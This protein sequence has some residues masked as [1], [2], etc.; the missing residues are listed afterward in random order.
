[1]PE[2]AQVETQ[3]VAGLVNPKSYT[4]LEEKIK[5]EEAELEALMKARTEEVEQ[6]A[7]KQ[8]QQEAKP[9]KAQEEA[10]VSGEERTYKKRYSDLRT[11][12]NKQAEEL[13]QMKAQ[14]EQ[15]QKEGKVRAPTSDES[16]D[17]W[18]KKYP[19]IA[20]IVE[21]IAEK[22]AQEKF[23]Y[24][25][26]RLKEI[27]EI[28]AQA[29]RTK[30]HNEIRAMHSDFDDLRSSDEF[31]DWAGEQPKWVQDALYENQDDPHSEKPVE[32]LSNKEI[33]DEI[34]WKTA[35]DEDTLI[36]YQT[37]QNDFWAGKYYDE[38][39]RRIDRRCG[40]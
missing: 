38:A 32:P 17:A 8:Q 19:E 37:Y 2:L 25:D 10:E 9:E 22:K 33:D 3:K 26:E 4:P 24:A 16:I 36:A 28:N 30:A 21:T 13:K 35:S 23:K 5:K 7:E 29:Q 15:V 20:G 14:L 18:A 27:D 1:M 6:K 39:Q 31:H 12:M 34:A 11:H 40:R